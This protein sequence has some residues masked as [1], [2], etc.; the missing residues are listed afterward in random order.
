MPNGETKID[1]LMTVGEL[2]KKMGTTV[3]ALQYYDKEGLLPPSGESEGGRRLYTDKDM[4]KL[5]QILSLKYLGFS[6]KDIK[7]RLPSLDSPCEIAEALS[8]QASAI[9]AKISELSN[10]LE[11][12]EALRAEVLQMKSVDFKKYADIIVNL[13]MENDMYWLIKYFDDKT[14]DSIRSRFDLNSGAQMMSTFT[15]L[16]ERALRLKEN[17]VPPES[18]EGQAFAKDFWDMIIEFTDGD[19]SVIPQLIEIGNSNDPNNEFM[20]NQ[21]AVNEY[22]KPALKEYFT[23]HGINPF[24]EKTDGIRNKSE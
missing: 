3:R 10:M 7:Y 17:G 6:L 24:T 11:A 14:L 8:E 23:R 15:R 21:E 9:K 4:V 12:T 13:Q 16:R 19:M 22:L 18:G 1:G 2:A 5:H 20:R